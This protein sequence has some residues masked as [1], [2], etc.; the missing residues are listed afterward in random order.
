[1]SYFFWSEGGNDKVLLGF[2]V[3]ISLVGMS[4]ICLLDD[5]LK[6]Q[7]GHLEQIESLLCKLDE[8]TTQE[9][10]AKE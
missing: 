3:L 2:V 1:M 5:K 4:N 10:G 8:R 7:N 6:S 9:A